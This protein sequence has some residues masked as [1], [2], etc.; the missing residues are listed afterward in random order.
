MGG[1]LHFQHHFSHIVAVIFIGEGNQSTRRKKQR[2]PASRDYH[3]ETIK[4][5]INDLDVILHVT[6]VF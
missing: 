1:Y 4:V 3:R 5:I 2:F 6:M